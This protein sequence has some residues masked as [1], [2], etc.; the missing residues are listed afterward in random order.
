MIKQI[1]TNLDTDSQQNIY[2]LILVSSSKAKFFSKIS[3]NEAEARYL[4]QD[5]VEKLKK[6]TSIIDT[7]YVD[8][9]CKSDIDDKFWE[10]QLALYNY[11]II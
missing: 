5:Y 11:L 6:N 10:K 1:C 3:H 7:K 2:N 4:K 8:S 9:I